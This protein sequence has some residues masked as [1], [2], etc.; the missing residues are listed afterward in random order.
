MKKLKVRAVAG[1]LMECMGFI[2]SGLGLAKM[3]KQNVLKVLTA[4]EEVIVN[5][6]N[7][8][9]PE[10]NGDLELIFEDQGNCVS[11]LFIDYGNPFNPLEKPD[12]DI[13][14]PIGER[15]VGG[16][17]ILMAKKLMDR[18][19]YE[20]KDGQNRLLIIKQKEKSRKT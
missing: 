10:S 20:Y 19:H 18:I 8:A 12:S 13:V 11:V 5:I 1:N 15:E 17:G 7:Y 2:E 6:I 16:L 4:C 3:D 14:S 9:Y